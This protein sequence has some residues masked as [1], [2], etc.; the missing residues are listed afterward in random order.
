MYGGIFPASHLSCHVSKGAAGGARRWSA[1]GLT[2]ALLTPPLPVA[3]CCG[4]L[5][6]QIVCYEL[7]SR[8]EEGA[9][10]E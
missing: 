7:L 6:E 2:W 10:A 8:G 1:P 4:A 9:G 3:A 5:C